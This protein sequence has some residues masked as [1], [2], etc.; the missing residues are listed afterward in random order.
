[1]HSYQQMTDIENY[2]IWKMNFVK[3]RKEQ[4]KVNLTLGYCD[5]N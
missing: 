5:Q 1:M 4:E 2:R 3:E